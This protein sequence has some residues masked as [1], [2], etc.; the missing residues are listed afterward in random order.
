MFSALENKIMEVL[1]MLNGKKIII[2]GYGKS[3]RFLEWFLK[4]KCRLTV[5]YIIDDSVSIYGKPIYRS[6]LLDCLD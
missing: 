2:W 1:P 4:E 6:F 3:G 5:D